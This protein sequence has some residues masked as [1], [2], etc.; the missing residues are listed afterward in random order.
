MSTV[1]PPLLPSGEPLRSCVV[2]IFKSLSLKFRR[3]RRYALE[4]RRHGYT[5]PIELLCLAMGILAPTHVRP[6]ARLPRCVCLRRVFN[7]KAVHPQQELTADQHPPRNRHPLLSTTAVRYRS[8]TRV[9]SCLSRPLQLVSIR[10][11]MKVA[12]ALDRYVTR[13]LTPPLMVVACVCLRELRR[14]RS[15]SRHARHAR[16]CV[17]TC[18]S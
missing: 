10:H 13:C 9:L 17:S 6:H 11:G 18:H 5:L 2:H 16:A 3:R 15:R 7:S 4:L 12:K 14:S 8:T 1:E